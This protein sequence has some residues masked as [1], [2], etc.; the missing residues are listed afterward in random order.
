MHVT[1]SHTES[2]KPAVTVAGARLTLAAAIV[3][4]LSGTAFAQNEWM[5]KIRLNELH[6]HATGSG[7]LIGQ[8]E[9]GTARAEHVALSGHISFTRSVAGGGAN[10]KHATH[11]ASLLVGRQTAAG[12]AFKGAAPSAKLAV[13]NWIDPA[14]AATWEDNFL[15]TMT[16]FFRVAPTTPIINMSAGSNPASDPA[17]EIT[18]VQQTADWMGATGYLFV[19]AAGNEGN[20]NDTLRSP[21][22]GYN[23]LTVGATGESG[24]LKNYNRVA[25]FS[26]R[27]PTGAAH[28]NKVDIVAP[29]T[30]IYSAR[31][32]GRAGPGGTTIYDRFGDND[33]PAPSTQVSGT[34]FATPIVSGVAASLHEWGV[35]KNLSRDPRV[36]RAVLMNSANKSVEDDAGVRWDKNP[37]LGKGAASISNS[38]GTGQLDAY[39]SWKQYS[40]GQTSA[41]TGGFGNV[42]ELGWDLGAVSGTGVFNGTTYLTDKS[43]R[44]GSYMTSTVA[45]NRNITSGYVE[46]INDPNFGTNNWANWNYGALNNFDIGV[47]EAS[48]FTTLLQQSN[49]TLGTSEHSVFKTP[50]SVRYATTVFSP[51]AVVG[52]ATYAHAWEWTAAPTYTK[53]Y[54]GT[55]SGVRGFY[56]DDG[57]YNPDNASVQGVTIT[58]PAFV[59]DNEDA[60]ALCMTSSNLVSQQV[61]A[62]YG[63]FTISFDFAFDGNNGTSFWA[64][65]GGASIFQFDADPNS[66]AFFPNPATNVNRYQRYTATITDAAFFQQMNNYTG[67]LELTFWTAGGPDRLYVD[68]LTYVPTPGAAALLALGAFS[69]A[70]RRRA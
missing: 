2:P 7:V 48:S 57:W 63:S 28:R 13:S 49:N 5:A 25:D 47:G 42:P 56:Q 6:N 22:S 55:F 15:E 27:G 66:S 68:N 29:G 52:N 64:T 8:V 31:E 50:K 59:P 58:K 43:V 30:M 65:L 23:V 17:A 19:A 45:Y 12:G 32:E 39:Q 9:S 62:P 14:G 40:A 53:Q 35:R 10:S 21:G 67:L 4:A 1:I 70:R 61:A 11:V 38:L 24:A 44:K 34:S 36:M 51:G 60:W 3:A 18:R 46:N 37:T 69:I 20:A 26:S 41:P 33:F 54:N 16:D